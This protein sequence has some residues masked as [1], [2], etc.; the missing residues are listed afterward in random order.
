[1]IPIFSFT[2]LQGEWSR[3]QSKIQGLIICRFL[4]QLII[5]TWYTELQ[6]YK[7]FQLVLKIFQSRLKYGVIHIARTHKR[8]GEGS[9]Q[10]RTNAHKQEG[11]LILVIFVRMNY[12]MTPIIA[13]KNRI[14]RRLMKSKNKIKKTKMLLK[15]NKEFVC[16]QYQIFTLGWKKCQLYRKFYF[17]LA[18][19]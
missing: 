9:S 14:F 7:K 6:L 12:V 11:G 10:M 15:I 17:G 13:S 3:I 16:A 4:C 1:M 2:F 5:S 18:K 8:R 19:G